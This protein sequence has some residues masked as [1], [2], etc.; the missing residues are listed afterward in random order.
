MTDIEQEVARWLQEVVIGLNLCPFAGRPAV[1]KRVRFIVSSAKDET[2]LLED[3]HA[4][5][6]HLDTT[7]VAELETTL[8]IVPDY[9]QDFFDYTRFLD[10]T[11]SWLKRN[12]WRGIYQIASFHP[13]YCFSGADP[14]DCENLTNRSP[15][16]I[17][18]LLRE[19]SLD[20]ALG[21][22]QDVELIPENNRHRMETLTAAQKKKLFPYLF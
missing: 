21:Y 15:Y 1:E 6:T 17:L 2:G 12:G 7:P 13:H 20:K 5:L 4:E 10:W 3:L 16:P 14:D 22:F 8:L 19:E 11:Q 9:L 18:H